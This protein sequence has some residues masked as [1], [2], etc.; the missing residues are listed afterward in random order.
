MNK[1]KTNIFF[2]ILFIIIFLFLI[3]TIFFLFMNSAPQDSSFGEYIVV[4]GASARLIATELKQQNFIKSEMLFYVISRFSNDTIK[5]GTYFI[6]EN[7]TCTSIFKQLVEGKQ[8]IIYVTV[9]EGLTL[10]KTAELFEQKG[11]VSS[12]DFIDVATN[13]EFLKQMS[14]KGKSAEGFLFPET[15][16]FYKN[17][18]AKDVVI[19]MVNQFWDIYKSIDTSFTDSPSEK[20]LSEIYQTV[21]L[22]S[23]VER[24]YQIPEEAPIIAGVFKNRIKIGMGLQSCATVEYIITEIQHKPHPGFITPNETSIDNPYNTYLWAGLPPGPIA[25][26]GK[27]AIDATINSANQGYHHFSETYEEHSQSGAQFYR[28][29]KGHK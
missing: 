19:A 27:V 11:I 14:I 22:S 2:N 4:D 7:S 29:L 13:P 24:E 25:N 12:K 1:S 17:T 28:T 8:E 10:S 15:Y 18:P 9:P 5:A 26:P 23:I 16:G 20:K 21:I 6:N 3:A